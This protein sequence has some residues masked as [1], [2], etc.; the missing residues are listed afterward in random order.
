[1]L[2]ELPSEVLG[3]IW[4]RLD[5]PAKLAVYRTSKALQNAVIPLISSVVFKLPSNISENPLRG[6]HPDVRLVKAHIEAARQPDEKN[7]NMALE[8][9]SRSG[10]LQRC[11]ELRLL[12]S[13]SV[14]Q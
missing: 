10:V 14:E 6:L 7:S 3:Q 13:N 12:V 4:L 5:G 1:M 8:L 9:L 11:Q 2:L